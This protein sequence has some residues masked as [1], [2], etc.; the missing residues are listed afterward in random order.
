[1]AD[2]STAV[3]GASI[4]RIRG[5]DY[6]VV[7]VSRMFP[8]REPTIDG[9]ARQLQLQ[10]ETVFNALLGYRSNG[11]AVIGLYR[12]K[13]EEEVP[14]LDVARHRLRV[15][16]TTFTASDVFPRGT[17]TPYL[18]WFVRPDRDA[19]IVLPLSQ[20]FRQ[21]MRQAVEQRQRE[22]R[23]RAVTPAI[24]ALREEMRAIRL[25]A[26]ELE[27]DIHICNVLSESHAQ[28]LAILEALDGLLNAMLR[29]PK[30]SVD[31]GDR[32]DVERLQGQLATLKSEAYRYL[33]LEPPDQF[34]AG[35]VGRRNQEAADLRRLI[36]A[37]AFRDNVQTLV[38]NRDIVPG[39]LWADTYDITRH[40]Y[41][42][43]L[44]SPEAEII[45]DN[46]VMPMLQL[47]A[48]RPLDL[49]EISVPNR[50][51]FD[52]EV[53]QTPAPPQQWTVLVILVG[54]SAVFPQAFGNYPGPNTL[55]VSILQVAAP[56]LMP[57]LVGNMRDAGRISAWMFRALVNA[58]NLGRPERLAVVRAVDQG[59]LQELR[60]VNWSSRF[61]NSAA[62][63][64]AIAVASA[65]CFIA[66]IQSD[67][68]STLR[69]WSNILGSASGT[70]L[71]VAVAVR[72]YS[73]LIEQG[74]VRGI[75]GRVLG[76]IGG[77]A[78]IVSG[79]VTAVE[80]Y[81][82]GDRVGMW[83]SI[84]G[85]AGGLLSVAGFLIGAGAAASGTGIGAPPG[86]VLMA[87]GAVIGIGAGVTVLVRSLLTAGSQ[88]IFEAF[89]NA[90]GE[91]SP[92]RTASEARSGLRQAF[93]AVQTAH[94]PVDFWDVHPDRIPQLYDL[95]F[96]AGHIA[97]I[98]D[99]DETTVFTSLRRGERIK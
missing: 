86:L 8:D 81:Q 63:G 73:T 12:D 20:S 45:L 4:R 37:P 2:V 67:D 87:I 3:P 97:Q 29:H 56:L 65:I 47:L 21:V 10:P 6:V 84:G 41:Q 91:R 64:A 33:I 19:P 31:A 78:A 15:E 34:R 32:L 1:M 26:I 27:S 16:G 83:I 94:H 96:S 7:R 92:Y 69:Y 89:I 35:L 52:R 95:G 40:A 36:E 17:E 77:T 23:L 98:V 48:S 61:M 46:H 30:G 54:A 75:G 79:T 44:G 9:L 76:V 55:A 25:K 82:T 57:R 28:D 74:I 68:A 50:P 53:R 38:D 70:A 88:T 42:V 49:T 14:P 59:N 72:Q 24:Q 43:L 80:E 13:I 62:W 18:A 58:A 5:T 60:R 22:M 39:D 85:A 93:E 90:F 66:A 51:D 99:E 71:G 11:P